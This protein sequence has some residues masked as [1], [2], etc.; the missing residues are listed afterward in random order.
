MSRPAFGV[1]D[2]AP[3][4]HPDDLVHRVEVRAR[5]CL[6]DVGRNTDAR[7]ELFRDDRFEVGFRDLDLAG[8]R[9]P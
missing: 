1:A 9:A 6:D 7:S 4:P 8:R 3:L 2:V 5:R